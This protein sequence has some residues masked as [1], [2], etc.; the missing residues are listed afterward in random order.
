M[1]VVLYNP[2]AAGDMV[3]AVIDSKDYIITH[4]K[5]HPELTYVGKKTWT[6][7]FETTVGML[8]TNLLLECEKE[9]TALSSHDITWVPAFIKKYNFIVIDD[10]NYITATAQRAV[11]ITIATYGELKH[12]LPLLDKEFLEIRKEW[13]NPNFIKFHGFTRIIPFEE[14]INGNLIDILKQW[15]DTPLNEDIYTEWLAN[16]KQYFT[17]KLNTN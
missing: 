14:I 1:H 13:L 6:L 17:D 11:D 16:N 10:S 15:V 2:G 8:K 12:H 9:Y 4:P 3:T 7:R 5:N